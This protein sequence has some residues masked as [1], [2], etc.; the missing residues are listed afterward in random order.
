MI[1]KP[2]LPK[3]YAKAREIAAR[4]PSPVGKPFAAAK[5]K[6][7]CAL[8]LYEG[9]GK[10]PWTGEGISPQDVLAALAEAKD[11]DSLDIHLNSPGGLVFD[12]IAIFNAIKSFPGKKT[13]Y[14][15]GI[16]ASI[17]S[18]I[19]LAGDRVVMNEGSMFMVHDPAGGIIA[20]GG[21]DDIEDEARKTVAA[22]RKVRENLLDLY[23]SATGQP[24]SEISAWMTA[25]TWMTAAEA[26]GRGFADEIVAAN[27]MGCECDGKCGRACPCDGECSDEC[28]CDCTA[29]EDSAGHKHKPGMSSPLAP[30]DVAA[31][32]RI[33]RREL[34]NKF[35]GAS[36]G[37][38]G[39]PDTN[40][41]KVSGDR[42]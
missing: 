35:A 33:K 29:A 6:K 40:S 10:D 14:V 5:Q 42:K 38:S 15:D 20:F 3:W 22:L 1:A 41:K 21:A 24:L 16:A 2:T 4:V 34:A 31:L 39:Q 23:Q 36:P 30:S 8:Y 19:A 12:G 25:E 17:A 18:V 26:K 13:V 27:A 7:H 9:I 28:G 11:A 32:A 37:Q